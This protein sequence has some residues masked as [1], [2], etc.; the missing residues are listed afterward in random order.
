MQSVVESGVEA[1]SITL[2]RVTPQNIGTII[3]YY[4]ILTSLIGSMFGVNTYNQ[5]GVELGKQIL[6]KNL[7]K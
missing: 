3:A 5:P 7:S 2:D 1:D 4:E 6:Y